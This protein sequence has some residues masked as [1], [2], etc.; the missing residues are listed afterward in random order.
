MYLLELSGNA[1]IV[2]I[3]SFY[4]TAVSFIYLLKHHKS[5]KR[6]ENLVLFFCC[7]LTFAFS[8]FYIV[9]EFFNSE[10]PYSIKRR[11]FCT[12]IPIVYKTSITVSQVLCNV[13][14]SYRYEAFNQL[15]ILVRAKRSYIFLT[16]FIGFSVF[17]LAGHVIYD[18]IIHSTSNLDECIYDNL[19]KTDDKSWYNYLAS[20][21]F[22]FEKFLKV[23]VLIEIMKPIYKYHMKSNTV[24]GTN[25]K[26]Q[27]TL[28]RLLWSTVMFSAGDI[29]LVIVWMSAVRKNLLPAPMVIITYL[30]INVLSLVSA[31]DDYAERIFPFMSIFKSKRVEKGTMRET[32]ENGTENKASC[33]S[34]SSEKFEEVV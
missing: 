26:V 4:I 32:K 8:S 20:G 23:F 7:L 11:F 18:T 6:K 3:L 16:I 34:Q 24:N 31:Y 12:L 13:I 9:L 22:F 30:F 14:L 17:Q 28:Y 5:K 29:Y 27:D 21:L 15:N 25:K 1:I 2:L 10:K 33:T 19:F